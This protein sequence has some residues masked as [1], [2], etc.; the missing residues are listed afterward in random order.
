[1]GA[2]SGGLSRVKPVTYVSGVVMVL[3]V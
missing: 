2:R 3:L 1:L